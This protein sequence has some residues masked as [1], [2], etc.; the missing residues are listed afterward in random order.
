MLL[1]GPAYSPAP[2]G[3]LD[4]QAQPG[5]RHLLQAEFICR[6]LQTLQQA[7]VQLL[8][9]TLLQPAHEEHHCSE[10]QEISKA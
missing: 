3:G 10:Q 4:L 6:L 7:G 1:A 9:V 8:S 2:A 5:G